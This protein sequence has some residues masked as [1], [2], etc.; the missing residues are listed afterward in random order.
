[1]KG[2]TPCHPLLRTASRRGFRRKSLTRGLQRVST[3]PGSR[4]TKRF[5]RSDITRA[6]VAQGGPLRGPLEALGTTA[7][8]ASLHAGMVGNCESRATEPVGELGRRGPGQTLREARHADAGRRCAGRGQAEQICCQTGPAR[9]ATHAR[10]G[11]YFAIPADGLSH[12]ARPDLLH[13]RK[14][15]DG[16]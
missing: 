3:P 6:S 11:R 5:V 13:D 4:V 14:R 7:E 12:T 15:S 10:L 16:A 2:A 8:P 9:V 1:M